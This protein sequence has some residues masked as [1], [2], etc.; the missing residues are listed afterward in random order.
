MWES[1]VLSLWGGGSIKIN[2]T[3]AI[4]AP[5]YQCMM[6]VYINLG[7]ITMVVQLL[8]GVAAIVAPLAIPAAA[9]PPPPP[10]PS[11]GI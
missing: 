1:H 2:G 4:L 8:L 9:P 11:T 10:D 7:G 6:H 5:T 3:I